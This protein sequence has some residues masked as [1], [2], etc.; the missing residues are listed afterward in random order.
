MIHKLERLI[1][2][3]RKFRLEQILDRNKLY[4]RSKIILCFTSSTKSDRRGS[5]QSTWMAH[6]RRS[7]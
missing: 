2:M 6:H 7:V 3:A 1:L 4:S 5:W